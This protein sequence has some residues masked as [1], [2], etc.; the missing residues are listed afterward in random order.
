VKKMSSISRRTLLLTPAAYALLKPF[1]DCIHARADAPIYPECLVVMFKAGGQ[2]VGPDHG[3]S[4]ANWLPKAGPN[5]EA[6]ASGK[7]T[8]MSPIL[9]PLAP[10]IEMTS[11][12]GGFRDKAQ[13]NSINDFHHSN[14][15]IFTGAA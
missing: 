12:V 7:I 15:N 8:A 14:P 11:V 10:A 4:S 2:Y 9:A 13:E 5:G 3:P 6:G 1:V